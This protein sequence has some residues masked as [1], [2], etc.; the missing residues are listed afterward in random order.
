MKRSRWRVPLGYVAGIGAFLLATPSPSSL[1]IGF[2]LA[3]AGESIRVWAS[4][5]I[6]KTLVLAT[7]G[8]YAHTRNPLYLGSVIMAI[9]F[10]LAAASAWVGLAVVLYFV[11]FYPHVMREEAEF[12]RERFSEDYA[13]W[14]STV[15]AFLP[16][17][18]PGGAAASRFSWQRVAANREW[19]TLAALPAALAVL[20]ARMWVRW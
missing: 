9:G 12:L 20:V 10:A 16:R 15:P 2:A 18:T 6:E 19:R 4:G 13:R 14:E 17:I 8:P 7:G 11:V 1:A 5:H 3:L